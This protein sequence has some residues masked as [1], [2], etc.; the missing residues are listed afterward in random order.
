MSIV[1]VTQ[2]ARNRDFSDAARFGDIKFITAKEI[3]ADDDS[4]DIDDVRDEVVSKLVGKFRPRMDRL[5]LSGDPII[6]AMC[7]GVLGR[8]GVTSVNC[9]KFDR[10]EGKYY[11]VRV[12]LSPL[13]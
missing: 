1:F 2:W 4:V 11:H 7:M 12:P 5:L 10:E 8:C 3:F 9:L 13:R 6:I